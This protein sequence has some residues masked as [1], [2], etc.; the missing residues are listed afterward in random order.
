MKKYARFAVLGVC[1]LALSVSPVSTAWEHHP[2][3]TGPVL[4][5][6]PG[7]AGALAELDGLLADVFDGFAVY[8]RSYVRAILDP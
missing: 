7:V 1:G 8:G 3:L 6:M 5:T 4:S 2:L